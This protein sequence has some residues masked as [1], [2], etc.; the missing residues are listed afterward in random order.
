MKNCMRASQQ[1]MIAPVNARLRFLHWSAHKRPV[2]FLW[3]RFGAPVDRAVYR[4]SRGRLSVMGP[5]VLLLTS[6]GR[7]SGQSRTTPVIYVRDGACFVISSENY[8]Q[9]RRAA[10][11]LNLDANPQATVQVGAQRIS[12]CSRRLSDAEAD[13]YWERLLAVLPAHAT[14]R[15]RSGERHTF[16]L[17][18][19]N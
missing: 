16:V 17:D 2:A 19:L 18:P 12:C 10:W 1:P 3:R 13:G 6:T 15:E 5:N 4:A 7:R 9:R 8:G 11:P 14:Y